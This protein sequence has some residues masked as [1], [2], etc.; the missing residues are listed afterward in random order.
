MSHAGGVRAH[1]PVILEMRGERRRGEAVPLR[2]DER[3]KLREYVRTCGPFELLGRE[4]KNVAQEGVHRL[5]GVP[6]F[7]KIFLFGV[8]RLELLLLVFRSSYLG[9]K[10]IVAHAEFAAEI[11]SDRFNA[12]A[13]RRRCAAG[14]LMHVTVPQNRAQNATDLRRRIQN[15]AEQK[16][17]DFFL[18]RRM[19]VRSFEK[20]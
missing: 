12:S 1:A 16:I 20:A 9:V 10:G 17:K 19:D 14:L 2:V 4:L 11:L 7:E 6:S 5:R 18:H 13:Q 3:M 15:V 8:R